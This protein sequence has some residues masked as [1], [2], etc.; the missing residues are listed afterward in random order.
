MMQTERNTFITSDT[1][2]SHANMLKFIRKDGRK[3]RPEFSS[4]E[5][6]DECLVE[7]WNALVRPN[8]IIYHLGDVALKSR[9][10]EIVKRLNGVKYLILGN[11]DIYGV[12]FYFDYFS[13]VCGMRRLLKEGVM[14]THIPIHVQS[15]KRGYINVH[16]HIHENIIAQDSQMIVGNIVDQHPLYFNACVEHHNYA[17][18]PFDIIKDKVNKVRDVA[19]LFED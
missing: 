1:H 4:V 7:R 16:G 18:I 15:I 6:M 11:H 2:F 19:Y 5:E 14:L 8:D 3:V 10:V 13:D 12:K 17:P 9:H